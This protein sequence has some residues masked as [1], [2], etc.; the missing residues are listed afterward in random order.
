MRALAA[1]GVTYVQM[2]EG[3]ASYVHDNWREELLAQGLDL[4]E[5]LA[6]DIAAE[7]NCWAA[8]FG[9]RHSG[10]THLPRQPYHGAW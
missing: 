6:A 10:N 4:E 1:D 3:F 9:T 2:D 7:N 5:E 8:S